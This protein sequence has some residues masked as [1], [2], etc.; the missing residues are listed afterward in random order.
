MTRFHLTV[1]VAW[2]DNK[3]DGTVCRNPSGNPYCIAL[4]RIREERNDEREDELA[5]RAWGE[6]EADDLPPC[7]AESA[8]FMNQ[9]QWTRTIKHP[10]Q[11]IAKASG[12]HGHLRPTQVTVPPF[13]T[14]AVP[15]NWMLRES[16]EQIDTQLPEPL[17]PDDRAP[18]PSPWVFGRARQ[19]AIGNL[20]FS[21]LEAGRSLVFFY[22]KE[23]QP[24]G[25]SV[26]RLVLG[27][28]RI[29]AIGPM[30]YYES[31][32][33]ATYPLWDRLIRHSIREDSVDGFLLPYHEYLAPTG[34]EQEDSH[35]LE[36]LREIAVPAEPTQ[37]RTFSFF[38]ELASPD[39]TLSTLIGCLDAVRRIRK[40]GIVPGPWDQREEWLNAQIGQA[41]KDRGAF[42]GLG[43]ALQALGMRLGTSLHLELLAQGTINSEED[44]WP[45]V[46]SIIRG[47]SPP[48]EPAYEADLRAV[49]GTWSGLEESRR[50]LLS[51][52]SRFDFTPKQA[53]RWFDPHK[54]AKAT[55]KP[56]DDEIVL[57][58]AYR[59]VE[60]DLGDAREPPVTLGSI[61]RGLLPDPTI[62]AHCP[63]PDNSRIDSP[64]DPRRIRA[65]LVTI[66]RKS[67][68]EG[69]SLLSTREAL[70]RLEGLD[71]SRPCSVPADWIL[72][73]APLL[74]D[75]VEV[76]R[77]PVQHESGREVEAVQL[78][79][80]RSFEDDLRKLLRARAAKSLPPIDEDW[81][82]LLREAITSAGGSV[83][84]TNIRHVEAL[85]DQAGALA[86]ITSR[87]LA[88]LVGRAGTGKT[89]I[90]GALVR[91]RGL[92][93]DGVLLLAPTG[94][95]RVKL[96]RA[97]KKEA[98]TIAQWLHGLGRYD[99][100]RQRPLFHGNIYR[101]EK[102]VIVDECSML[103]MVDLLAVL[104]ALDLAHV[105]RIIL[106]GD[107]NQLPPIGVGRP[108]ADFVG[109]LQ[110]APES[111][112]PAERAL[113]GALA[114]LEVE[115][116]TSAGQPSDVL[117]LASWFTSERQTVDSDRVLGDVELGEKFVDL[118]ICYW[119]NPEELRLR[120]LEQF[121]GQ[122]RLTG[123]QDVDGWNQALG[124]DN[125]GWVPFDS[126]DGAE[127]FQILSPVR[128]RPHGVFEL[129]R[130]IQRHFR[131]GELSRA[132]HS[133]KTS[134]GD[135]EIVIRDK[136]IQVRNERRNAWTGSD[137]VEDY[138]A[139]GEVG[140]VALDQKGWLKVVF[141]GRPNLTFSYRK[142]DFPG[143][144]GPLE[145][146][147][148]LTVHKAQGSE[149]RKV[150]VIVPKRSL[151]LSRELLYTALTRARD[152][153]V[154][155]VEGND[156]SFLYDLSRP[157]RSE[158]ARRNTNLFRSAV[159][160]ETT[161]TPWAEHLIHRTD[162][163]HMVRSKSE[164]VI[165][166]KLWHLKIEYEYERPLE[167]RDPDS[168]RVRKIRPDF[169]FIDPGGDVV[170]WEHLGMLARPE[171]R[172][173]WEWKRRWYDANG[174]SEGVN[175]FTS[176]DD[177]RG[178][179]NS[180]ELE[181]IA[182]RVQAA[183]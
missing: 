128:M 143:G 172:E 146:A 1:R 67:A 44:P 150:F 20:F 101:K 102:T 117:R 162:K 32:S 92:S 153:L 23:G 27:V 134:L 103:T 84:S 33:S 141:A 39:V 177:E 108:F 71:L 170:I 179:L 169:S 114:R 55:S 81:P 85:K 100:G 62:M 138:L 82:T 91:S 16:Q 34:D 48:P 116:R 76:L 137:S 18:F 4:D 30:G 136:V 51:L 65:C 168:G 125:R 171:Y 56:V 73:N 121:Q 86:T 147:Y 25:D 77:V 10:Y 180:Q 57:K 148:A 87:K 107:P 26:S 140:V 99:G 24:L 94:K 93:V 78:S 126:P 6:L 83:D 28:G 7:V 174:Y 53:A 58:N 45:L 115:V 119:S 29:T 97:T 111:E 182:E 12:T 11:T 69:D 59:M 3:W 40:H 110:Q 124:M 113:G 13:S 158:T 21:R 123:P 52:L 106:V 9:L 163:G 139:N 89:S 47:E 120:L 175:L 161:S 167:G 8:G 36:L 70:E 50:S 152:H 49:R 95:A 159:R 46:D 5:G 160:E 88:V 131:A 75:V 90:M 79:E 144:S 133:W 72:G 183:L 43:S 122:L 37:I 112:D 157:E 60:T 41:W 164:L 118:D 15:F 22:T 80:L 38:A 154:L 130:W 35:R 74:T 135:E 2:H 149:F 127:N 98:L 17:P 156:S 64:L 61:D 132:R 66:L 178:G 42:P 54:R 129:N 151:L 176:Q 173:G 145:L 105:Q 166:N 96:A 181:P 63:V 68:D 165:A 109:I 14:F 19:E 142:G 31:A 104:K 155:L